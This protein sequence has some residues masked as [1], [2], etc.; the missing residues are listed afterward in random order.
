MNWINVALIISV[1]ILAFLVFYLFWFMAHP[2][3]EK[4]AKQEADEWGRRHSLKD[5]EKAGGREKR[6]KSE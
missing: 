4:Q 2:R 5:R 6:G 1:I 3:S